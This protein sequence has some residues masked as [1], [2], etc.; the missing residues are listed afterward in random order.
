MNEKIKTVISVNDVNI[1]KSEDNKIYC[2]V[3][4]ENLMSEHHF[5]LI[6][7]LSGETHACHDWFKCY[8]EV[9]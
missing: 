4:G 1:L 5:L 6:Q 8:R 9:V 3:C 7:T 2:S